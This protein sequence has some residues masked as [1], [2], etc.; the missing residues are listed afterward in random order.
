MT[1]LRHAYRMYRAILLSLAVAVLLPAAPGWAVVDLPE[2]C[3]GENWTYEEVYQVAG[4]WR[5]DFDTGTFTGA[6]I[7]Y[8]L[9]DEG[10]RT[11]QKT[12]Q[13][14][15]VYVLDYN[16]T[17][18]GEATFS[19]TTL[20]GRMRVNN[21][22][23]SGQLWI[24][25]SDLALVSRSRYIDGVAESYA[26]GNWIPITAFIAN[27][28]EEYAPPLAYYEFP[29]GQSG[30]R[31]QPSVR[32]YL[33][34]DYRIPFLGIDTFNL[35]FNFNFRH[36]NSAGGSGQPDDIHVWSFDSLYAHTQDSYYN[37]ASK[38]HYLQTWT[39]LDLYELFIN[40]TST[41]FRLLEHWDCGITPTP[42]P[43]NT[44]TAT[45]TT[46]ETETPTPTETPTSTPTPTETPTNPPTP[47]PTNTPPGTGKSTL[48]LQS[49]YTAGRLTLDARAIWARSL[50]SPEWSLYIAVEA[51]GA[52]FFMPNF[53][54]S[55]APLASFSLPAQWDSGV[56]RIGDWP[57]SPPPPS[58]IVLTWYG[59]FLNEQ[60]E[61]DETGLATSPVVIW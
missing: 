48:W 29:M 2:W 20:N 52:F 40:I 22:R 32:M 58:P 57:I 55:P 47:F 24:R 43:S 21:A 39:N 42:S 54:E 23:Y 56:V 46:E 25:K 26:S 38:W 30:S 1:P 27:A 41:E 5:S 4:D 44:P 15:E 3:I 11:Q 45:P 28:T 61:L 53:T 31:T 59:A 19:G 33:F 8:T 16:T 60:G 7:T 14:Y 51:G 18:Y 6:R 12:G 34:G 49:T 36:Q 35:S 10:Y 17:V 13:S 9:V 37:D 50:P